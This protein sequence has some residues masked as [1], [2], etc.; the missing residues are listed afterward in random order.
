MFELLTIL[1]LLP[2][3]FITVFVLKLSFK[4]IILA[5]VLAVKLLRLLLKG[6]KKLLCWIYREI[7]ILWQRYRAS[8][9]SACH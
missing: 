4:L 8:R 3:I 5:L 1:I 6:V 9:P 2:I 7:V